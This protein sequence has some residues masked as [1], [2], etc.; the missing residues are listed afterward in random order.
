MLHYPCEQLPDLQ[1]AT[2][3]S[4]EDP[5]AD[6]ES[7]TADGVEITLENV[8]LCMMD[9]N[10]ALSQMPTNWSIREFFETLLEDYDGQGHVSQ[11][12]IDAAIYAIDNLDIFSFLSRTVW[13]RISEIFQNYIADNV[14]ET[15]MTNANFTFATARIHELF[16]TSAYR[17]DLMK[18]FN[19]NKWQDINDGQRTIGMKLVFNLYH[20][21]TAEVANLVRREEETEPIPFEVSMMGPEGK[22]KVRYI[23]GWAIRKTLEKSRKYIV[24]HKASS[25]TDV[26]RK[27][28]IELTKTQLLE[29]N[30]IMPWSVLK[31]ST[32]NP[33]TLNVV[34]SR[35]FRERGLL[36]ISDQAQDFFMSLEQARV[37]KINKKRLECLKSD[38]V[39]VSIEEVS[40]DKK[41]EVDFLDCYESTETQVCSTKQYNTTKP[42]MSTQHAKTVQH[43]TI[44]HK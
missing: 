3:E 26:L 13:C 23:G 41:L 42:N 38:V 11:S 17:S 39:E 7:N 44:K 28:R 27:V 19:V 37:D 32:S 21:F 18:A 14:E 2:G 20:L 29:D 24:D 16:F 15:H 5:K 35:Q 10:D 33:D 6:F 1:K 34:E 36:H 30:V 12:I 22:G 9:H 40:K 4:V 8:P 25:S 43:E 31:S